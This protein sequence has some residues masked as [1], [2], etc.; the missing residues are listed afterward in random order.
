MFLLQRAIISGKS[1]K[2][3]KCFSFSC[4]PSVAPLTGCTNYW[5]FCHFVL[6]IAVECTFVVFF[7]F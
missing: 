6:I 1:Q 7:S 5:L 2:H 3:H 4:C